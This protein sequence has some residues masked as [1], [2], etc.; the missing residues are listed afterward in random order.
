MKQLNKI[1]LFS[2][3]MILGLAVLGFTLVE[4]K[5]AN[6]ENQLKNGKK[7]LLQSLVGSHSLSSISA[8]MGANTMSNYFIEK[9][10]WKAVSSFLSMG[11]REAYDLPLE[12]AD[13]KT[14]NGLKI[15]VGPDLSVAVTVN[16]LKYLNSSFNENGVNYQLKKLPTEYYQLPEGFSSRT[17]F[18]EGY[19]YIFAGD[20]IADSDTAFAEFLG[21]MRDAAIIRYNI[22]QK[23]FELLIFVEECCDSATMSF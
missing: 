14:L 22:E 20:N 8:L 13:I 19:L 1:L 7:E 4:S 17:I 16:G 12:P 23:K 11:Q 18:A 3:L 5:K 9:G 6:I 21:V 15:T 10:E 2:F